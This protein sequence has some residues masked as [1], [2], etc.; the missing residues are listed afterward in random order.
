MLSDWTLCLKGGSKFPELLL[1]TDFLKMFVEAV[2]IDFFSV[3]F[4]FYTCGNLS[5]LGGQRKKKKI[6]RIT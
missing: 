3:F 2:H 1:A 4:V 5:I 6:L